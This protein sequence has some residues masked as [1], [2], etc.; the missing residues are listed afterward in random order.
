MKLNA[1]LPHRVRH[2][3][4]PFSSSPQYLQQRASLLI[5]SWAEGSWLAESRGSQEDACACTWECKAALSM[6]TRPLHM[7]LSD[8]ECV[9]LV[10]LP[11]NGAVSPLAVHVRINFCLMAG[12]CNGFPAAPSLS[13][14]RHWRWLYAGGDWQANK[15]SIPPFFICSSLRLPADCRN[16]LTEEDTQMLLGAD[17]CQTQLWNDAEKRRIK[18]VITVY[19]KDTFFS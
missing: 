6:L 14:I 12:P 8:D 18:N 10:Q 17:N 15:T 4:S 1:A 13:D 7:S 11:L 5:G 2:W 9:G 16:I 19:H 3:H